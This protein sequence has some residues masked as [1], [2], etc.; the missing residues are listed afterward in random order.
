M[1]GPLLVPHKYQKGRG[2]PAGLAVLGVSERP[3]NREA[4]V[5][6]Q[7]FPAFKEAKNPLLPSSQLW[8]PGRNGR[9]YKYGY[10]TRS[11]GDLGG[12][13]EMDKQFF[14]ASFS[15]LGGS[16]G[17]RRFGRGATYLD[18]R[19][20]TFGEDRFRRKASRKWG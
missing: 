13:E 5:G 14:T 6:R 7:R 9:D 17:L 11:A 1:S 19:E 4:A 3:D 20:H 15:T 2:S 10:L 12:R 16:G 18:V 8:G